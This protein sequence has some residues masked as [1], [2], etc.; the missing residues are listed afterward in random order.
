MTPIQRID[1]VL[2]GEKPNRPPVSFW[3]HFPADAAFG[4]NAVRAHLDHLHAYQLDFLKV[5]NDNPYPH[6]GAIA[7]IDDLASLKVLVGN[8]TGFGRQLELVAALR[9]ATHGQVYLVTTIFNA[10][11]TLRQL[12]KAMDTSNKVDAAN[13]WLR[14]VRSRPANGRRQPGAIRSQMHRRRRRWDFPFG[15][16]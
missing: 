15:A 7:S 13:R 1:A 5:M 9:K 6:E 16:R 10:W 3:Y 11:A 12:V 2:R 8:E 14:A 4:D